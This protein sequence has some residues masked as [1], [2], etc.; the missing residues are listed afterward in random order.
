MGAL[1]QQ[2]QHL[3]LLQ[4]QQQQQ[5]VRLQG[6]QQQQPPQ[7]LVGGQMMSGSSQILSGSNHMLSGSSLGS[8]QLGQQQQ[9]QLGQQVPAGF[10]CPLTRAVMRDPVM[11]ADGITYER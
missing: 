1:Q 5:Q 10:L 11:A 8:G 3:Q 6:L 2:I 4:Q 9:Q 7:H